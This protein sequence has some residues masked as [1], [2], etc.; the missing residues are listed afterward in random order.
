MSDLPIFSRFCG[1]LSLEDGSPMELEDFQREMLDG[2]FAGAIETLILISKK[3]GKSTLLAA[4]ALLSPDRDPGR[5]VRDRR[6]QPRPGD[7][8]V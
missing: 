6:R 8:P 7:D 5:G 3:N 2:Y 4:L 1:Q